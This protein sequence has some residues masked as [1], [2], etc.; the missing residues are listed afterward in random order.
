MLD[1]SIH[2]PL[3]LAVTGAPLAREGHAA[4]TGT[5]CL[6]CAFVT[7]AA[8]GTCCQQ[9]GRQ[10]TVPPRTV[11]DSSAL[12]CNVP[13]RRPGPLNAA[14]SPA[15]RLQEPCPLA[16]LGE[17]LK[18]VSEWDTQEQSHLCFTLSKR[19]ITVVLWVVGTCMPAPKRE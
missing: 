5:R 13:H 3:S 18:S 4:S 12:V 1:M 10:V 16:G 7:V 17:R 9:V 19:G 8:A 6:H 14:P 11:A 15:R 2:Y